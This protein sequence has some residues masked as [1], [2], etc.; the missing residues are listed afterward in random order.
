MSNVPNDANHRLAPNALAGETSP[1]LLQHAYNPVLWMPWSETAWQKARDENKLVLVSIG[2]AACHWCHVM[3]RESFENPAIAEIMNRDFICLKIDREERP[4]IDQVY[5]E[6]V[7]LLS[8]HAGWPLNCFC[9]PDGRPVY[10]GTYFR[11]EQWANLLE[12]LQALWR[13]DPQALGEQAGKLTAA[14]RRH[15]DA[16][17]RSGIPDSV[18]P[19]AE[20]L[21][22]LHEAVERAKLMFDR[23]EGGAQRAPKFPLP[24]NW[25]FLLRYG[26][27]QQD[28]AV[29]AQVRLTLDKMADGGIHDQI[30]GGF[31]RYSV[32]GIWKVPHFEKMLYDNGQLLG[33][34]A[35]AYAVFG[36]AYYREVAEKLVGFMQRDLQDRGGFFYASLDADSEGVEGKYYV[37]TREE[38]D[39]ALGKHAPIFAA[40]HGV[41]ARGLWEE[42]G[43]EHFILLRDREEAKIASQ[44]GLSIEAMRAIDQESCAKLLALRQKRIPPGL[45][46]KVLV[47]WNALAITGLAEAGLWL[48]NNAYLAAAEK[49]AE[50]LLREAVQPDGS[51]RRTRQRGI[52][53]IAGFLEDYAHFAYAL[54]SLHR[55]TQKNEYARA[56]ESLVSYA[57]EHFSDAAGL[58]FYFTSDLDA[59]LVARKLELQDNVLPSANG[60][61]A[62]C[63]WRLGELFERPQW[64]DRAQ[65]MVARM[66][67]EISGYALA[68]GGWAETA[69]EMAEQHSTVS[70]LGPHATGL[71]VEMARRY[72]PQAT[73][74]AQ[75]ATGK[76]DNLPCLQGQD[77]GGRSLYVICRD[78]TCFQPVTTLDEAL[79]LL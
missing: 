40:L 26:H 13:E 32:D 55:A 73:V 19:R 77:S 52:F 23:A 30:G 29:L 63:L 60:V 9:M 38:L 11:P 17:E 51:L 16:A 12:R 54:L 1:Y 10:G 14:L 79:K 47:S 56:A 6:A 7:Q 45:D 35:Q 8:G 48:Q 5:I 74:V 27:A 49:A 50:A 31:A 2:Y 37:W 22:E 3:E 20:V 28:K 64:Q 34:Y 4:D 24:V 43:E 46:D 44:F 42:G 41:D 36:D 70:V 58:F 59:P 62:R 67:P 21:G 57:I 75:S 25:R 15:E 78:R 33:L 53:A 71:A 69:F 76:Q 39:A 65:A 61:I 18:P 66:L 72:L 68:H